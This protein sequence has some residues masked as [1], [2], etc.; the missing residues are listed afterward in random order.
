MKYSGTFNILY[1]THLNVLNEMQ[2]VETL[3][4]KLKLPFEN[5]Y[6]WGNGFILL[7]CTS[8]A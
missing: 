6:F 7:V 3:S 8:A 1:V 4:A 5:I 2:K